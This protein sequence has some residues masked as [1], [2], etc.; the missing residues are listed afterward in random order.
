MWM[1]RWQDVNLRLPAKRC[2][3]LKRSVCVADRHSFKPKN[4][5]TTPSINLNTLVPGANRYSILRPKY[6]VLS[7]SQSSESPKLKS[8]I[9]KE[10]CKKEQNR[11]DDQQKRKGKRQA[12]F[13]QPSVPFP[14]LPS[15][16]ILPTVRRI[17]FTV[18]G[19]ALSCSPLSC[20]IIALP[21]RCVVY[22]AFARN[23][24]S[25]GIAAIP[26]PWITV[27]V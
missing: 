13:L 9:D 20:A 19:R 5:L 21:S 11:K 23:G 3:R 27:A 24:G 2:M 25:M 7:E 18:C 17:F 10:F 6:K 15:S 22:M 26:M 12:I 4:A 14:H 8:K 1:R 16:K